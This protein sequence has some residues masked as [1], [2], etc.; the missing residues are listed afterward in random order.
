MA[1]KGPYWE[2][3]DIWLGIY[4]TVDIVRRY[5]PVQKRWNDA[6]RMNLYVCVVPCFPIRIRWWL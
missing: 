6:R 5:S 1:W 2:P 3:R 4:W